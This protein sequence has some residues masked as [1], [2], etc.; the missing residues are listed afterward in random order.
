MQ[1]WPRSMALDSI[2]A[3]SSGPKA[4][5]RNISASAA[6]ARARGLVESS[7]RVLLF[8]SV[9]VNQRI[10]EPVPFLRADSSGGLA[11]APIADA[12]Y[13]AP[14]ETLRRDIH[15]A[16]TVRNA[17]KAVAAIAARLHATAL[18]TSGQ[19]LSATPIV[20]YHISLRRKRRPPTPQNEQHT[21]PQW[22]APISH[23]P[24]KIGP[25]KLCFLS[26]IPF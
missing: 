17:P 10:G 8:P 22:I 19:L 26:N 7:M 24:L 13:A 1:P 3:K 6:I 18:A 5:S 25:T 16:Q 20:T 11:A 12:A 14:P 2:A 9:V 4:R 15:T 21:S 23:Y